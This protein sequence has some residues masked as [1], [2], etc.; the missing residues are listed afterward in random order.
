M[1]LLP[2]LALIVGLPLSL[3]FIHVFLHTLRD[4]D[5]HKKILLPRSTRKV[6]ITFDKRRRRK[7]SD[8][9][10]DDFWDKDFDELGCTTTGLMM[11]YDRNSPS[12]LKF[13]NWTSASPDWQDG[14][15]AIQVKREGRSIMQGIL[16][17]SDVGN[18]GADEFPLWSVKFEDGNEEPL[19]NCEEWRLIE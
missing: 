18:D 16:E 10:I 2:E 1:S 12:R 14:G 17:L 8:M 11:A 9:T 6:C 19:V 15:K 5:G 7:T 4:Y 13:G 3:Y